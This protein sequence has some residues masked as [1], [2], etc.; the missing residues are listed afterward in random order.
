MPKCSFFNNLGEKI[1]LS[2][3]NQSSA[4]NSNT[5]NLQNKVTIIDKIMYYDQLTSSFVVSILGGIQKIL[6]LNNSSINL[7]INFLPS[8]ITL[9]NAI[10]K[11]Q[12]SAATSQ[13]SGI[14][15]YKL[16]AHISS[17]SNQQ[18]LVD[19]SGIQADESSSLLPLTTNTNQNPNVTA[20][21]EA[22]F[23]LQL[24]GLFCVL[25]IN[26]VKANYFN[27][28]SN[29]DSNRDKEVGTYMDLAVWVLPALI[30][31]INTI[32]KSV[33]DSSIEQI[34]S[35]PSSANLNI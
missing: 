34:S 10:L 19:Q 7:I 6:N 3:S 26:V 12:V 13:L 15:T 18:Q 27:S 16:G 1:T 31:F 21:N 11:Q 28:D 32:L 24:V 30:T 2:P 33:R 4:D 23:Y 9:V 20:I 35:A 5:Q 14:S 8:A 17:S 25:A 29:S 22:M